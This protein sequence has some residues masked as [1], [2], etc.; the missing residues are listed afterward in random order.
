VNDDERARDEVR[1]VLYVHG[2]ESGPGGRKA[3]NLAAAG[4]RVV[5]ELMPCGRRQIVRDPVVIAGGAALLAVVAASVARRSFLGVGLTIGLAYA[6]APLAQ[7]GVMRRVVRRSLA[8]Q[9]ASLASH[10]I[11]AVVGSSFG[12]AIALELLSRGLWS[13]PTVLLCPAHALVA[14]RA[15]LPVP[16]SLARLPD[17]VTSRIVVVHGLRDELVPVV[18]SQTLTDGSRAR[19]VLVDDGHRLAKTATPSRLAEWIAMA[20]G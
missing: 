10:R 18:D 12:G 2:L 16:P 7:A 20:Q 3:Q 11:E 6:C 1:T 4:F 19:L 13:G 14:G 17:A 9:T 5:S 15:R 8:V